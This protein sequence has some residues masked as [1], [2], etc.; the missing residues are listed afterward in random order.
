MHHSFEL[1]A[2]MTARGGVQTPSPYMLFRLA[3]ISPKQLGSC[4]LPLLPSPAPQGKPSS[5]MA[6]RDGAGKG[7]GLG[8][9]GKQLRGL[10]SQ[11]RLTHGPG[12]G[13]ERRGMLS[14]P[15]K[16]S[17]LHGGRHRPLLVAFL[18]HTVS[19]KMKNKENEKLSMTPIRQ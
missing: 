9:D 2:F 18:S 8:S 7:R 15:R 3:K 10:G 13:E 14:C 1:S 11:G 6:G 5:A 4:D 16:T 19:C 12:Q 17:D